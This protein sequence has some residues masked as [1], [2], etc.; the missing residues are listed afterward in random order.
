[1]GMSITEKI[2]ANHAG[3]KKVSP[4]DIV[5]VKVDY[6]MQMDAVFADKYIGELK[7]VWDPNRVLIVLDHV[8]PAA[9]VV[10]AEAHRA[11]RNFAKKFGIK[12]FYDLGRQG[13]S[14]EVAAEKGFLRPGE[15]YACADSHTAT[16]GAFNCAGRGVGQLEMLHVMA[17]GET[18]FPVVDTLRF[19]IAGKMPEMVMSKDVI[20]YIAAKY[21]TEVAANKNVEFTGSTVSEWSVSSRVTV[22]NMAAEISAEFCLFE[23]DQKLIDYVR[24]KTNEPFTPVGPDADA[25]YLETYEVDA[26]KIEPQVALPHSPG[27]S[28]PVSESEGLPIDHVFLGTCTNGRFEDLAVAAQILRGKKV[29]PDVRMVITP[30]THETYAHALDAG[31]IKVF[32]D[33]GACVTNP[34]CG[35]CDGGHLGLIAGGDRCISTGNRNFQGRMGSKDALIYL[36]SPATAAASA[37]T[38]KITDPRQLRGVIC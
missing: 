34:T 29:H 20:L 11:A 17:T 1:M 9:N 27:N 35:A 8:A 30:T 25:K 15:L 28:R 18:W 24:S 37:V 7:K 5:T 31:L 16:S 2:L 38:G 13:I 14:H 10:M 22:A 23:A 4:G 33:A 19:R 32:I 6:A 36:A 21:G 3:L 12:H 26:S